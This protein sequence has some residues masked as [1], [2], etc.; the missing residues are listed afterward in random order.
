MN[1]GTIATLVEDRGFGFISQEGHED[2]IFFHNKELIGV[3][4]EDLAV[5]DKV[6]FDIG[7][8]PK[9]LL[10]ANIQKVA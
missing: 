7:E 9:G 5:D 8:G 6:T 10:A 3:K 1:E 2:N 4:F